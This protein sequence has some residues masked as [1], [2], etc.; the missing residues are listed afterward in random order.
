MLLLTYLFAF[1][2]LSP[3]VVEIIAMSVCMNNVAAHISVCIW[4]VLAKGGGDY[5][6]VGMHKYCYCTDGC[7][8]WDGIK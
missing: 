2:W 6:D 8:H 5:C 7:L 4:V 3:R 1:G